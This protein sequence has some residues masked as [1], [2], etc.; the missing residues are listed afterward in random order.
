MWLHAATGR[1]RV[2][3][4]GWAIVSV[5]ELPSDT[6]DA[7]RKFTAPLQ[8]Q[9]VPFCPA[10]TQLIPPGRSLQQLRAQRKQPRPPVLVGEGHA[11]SH[12]FEVGLRVEAIGVDEG[13]AGHCR[14]SAADGAG[15]G[16]EVEMQVAARYRSVLGAL[17][18]RTCAMRKRVAQAPHHV[19][20]LQAHA[21]VLPQPQGPHIHR[22][23]GIGGFPLL[24][25]LRIARSL[26][27]KSEMG[28]PY[29]SSS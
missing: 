17:Q 22:I 20:G 10:H 3:R 19:P 12:L 29:R 18:P 23:V 14:D 28:I 2:W 4:P 9:M 25:R 11:R 16:V 7:N 27:I 26:C 15:S 21:Y 1:T 5:R 8:T 13:A 24:Q 6:P